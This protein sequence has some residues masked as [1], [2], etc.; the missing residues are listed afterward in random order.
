MGNIDFFVDKVVRGHRKNKKIKLV[1]LVRKYC[2]YKKRVNRNYFI[3]LVTQTISAINLLKGCFPDGKISESFAMEEL[4]YSH[5]AKPFL[6]AVDIINYEERDKDLSVYI[7]REFERSVYN[8][9]NYQEVWKRIKILELDRVYEKAE[10]E[11]VELK[12][13][14]AVRRDI[15]YEEGDCDC[16]YVTTDP[17]IVRTVGNGSIGTLKTDSA[18]YHIGIDLC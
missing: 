15:P 10:I 5:E 9:P 3:A 4:G 12:K 13:T 8:F 2:P 18:V 11:A 1:E 17:S 14:G 16:Y 6:L 7:R